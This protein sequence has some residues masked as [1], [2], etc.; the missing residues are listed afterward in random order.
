LLQSF[1]IKGFVKTLDQVNHRLSP[2]IS[3]LGEKDSSSIVTIEDNGNSNLHESI[4]ENDFQ[5]CDANAHF[6]W[7]KGELLGKGAFGK[8]Y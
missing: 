8:V 5:N 1:G 7:I 6:T 2:I 3:E 4:N